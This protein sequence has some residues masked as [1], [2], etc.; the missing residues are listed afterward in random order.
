MILSKRTR[1]ILLVLLV[2]LNVILRFQPKFSE[3]GLDSF[4]VHAMI[5]S[6][7]EF[8]Y[9]KWVLHPLSFFG[10]TPYSYTSSV[11]F[12]ISGI[13]Q[14]TGLEVEQIILA[15]TFIFGTF[16]IFPIYLLAGH[17]IKDDIFKFFVAFGYSTCQ[18]ILTYTTLTI[19]TRGLFI[20]LAP[21]GIFLLLKIR[22]GYSDRIGTEIGNDF[23]R[24]KKRYVL[25]F[26]V[27]FTLLFT[28]HHLVYFL[29][30]VVFSFLILIVYE[31]VL[32]KKVNSYAIFMNNETISKLIITVGFI[33]MY[34]IP[35]FTGKFLET[36]RYSPIFN[37]YIRYSGPLSI[38]AIGGII[39]LIFK[40]HKKFNEMF[41]VL[42]AMFLTVF[43]YKV[44]YMKWFLPLFVMILAGFGIM[45]VCNL[46]TKKQISG[47]T[48]SIIIIGTILF[49]GYFQ[50]LSVYDEVNINRVIEDSTI[51][52]STWAKNNIN[53]YLISNNYLEGFRMSAV[54]DTTHFLT[55]STHLD[56]IYGFVTADLSEF[57]QRS[58]LSEEFY[59]GSYEGVDQGELNWA[60]IN[61]LQMHPATFNLTHVMEDLRLN[62]QISWTHKPEVSKLL[63][64]VYKNNS[65]YD[66]GHIKIWNV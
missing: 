22:Q 3:V 58:P 51:E 14:S 26:I 36:S 24:L 56:Q 35:F 57:K 34:S 63:V 39:Y 53:G 6:L 47:L 61:R 11:Q 10:L 55:G 65:I 41:I 66:N 33:A 49:S 27:F 40:D 28:T 43:I 16:S 4:F 1:F 19:P 8:G 46:F 42:S 44:T 60:S 15:V 17:I 25:L 54:T 12:L 38:F 13:C 31:N 48:L 9:G 30:P 7:N 5:N 64:S 50:F 32:H 52:A 45:N 29:I 23:V 59:R 37:G 2:V 18:A 21:I 20:V 62:G